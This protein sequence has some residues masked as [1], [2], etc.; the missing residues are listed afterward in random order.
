MRNPRTRCGSL[1]IGLSD[2][3]SAVGSC[4]S[5]TCRLYINVYNSIFELLFKILYRAVK[6][7]LLSLFFLSLSLSLSIIVWS[8]LRKKEGNRERRKSNSSRSRLK[9]KKE[10]IRT[11][12]KRWF[13]PSHNSTAVCDD[14]NVSSLANYLNRN[15]LIRDSRSF[16]G[17]ERER[18]K[19]LFRI[20]TFKCTALLDRPSFNHRN[21]I[22]ITVRQ[23]NSR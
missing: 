13:S 19:V 18:K 2:E 11:I 15:S 21:S 23:T 22:V 16:E 1:R 10:N 8:N 12:W 20:N 17:R 5:P 9:K 4:N 3:H 14:T 7:K 6:Q